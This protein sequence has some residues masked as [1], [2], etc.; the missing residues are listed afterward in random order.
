MTEPK[1]KPACKASIGTLAEAKAACAAYNAAPARARDKAW[2]IPERIRR[3]QPHY[4]A[5]AFSEASGRLGYLK[6]YAE[7]GTE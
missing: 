1:V 6:W 7:N 2:A 5:S 4:V 3:G